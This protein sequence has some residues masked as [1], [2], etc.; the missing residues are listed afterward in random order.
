[1]QIE[2]FVHGPVQTN[3]FLVADEEANDAWVIDAPPGSAQEVLNAAAQHDWRV[4]ALINTHGHWDHIADNAAIRD[5]TGAPLSIH[6][7]DEPM[8]QEPM[9]MGFARGD[10]TPTNADAYL[11]EGDTLH[12]GR[13][14]FTVWH[15]PGHSPGGV[16][17]YEPTTGTLIGGDTLFPKGH[18]RIDIPGASAEEMHASLAR[19]ATLPPETVVYPGHGKSTTIGAER[20]WMTKR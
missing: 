4:V 6:P 14:T 10:I 9:Q 5:A 2:T 3:A 1:M 17:L 15:T 8:I 12:L 18:G 13:Y 20:S 16:V 11:N 7:A 19:L